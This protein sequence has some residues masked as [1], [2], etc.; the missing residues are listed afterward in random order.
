VV[1][2]ERGYLG[3]ASHATEVGDDVMIGKG[4]SVPLIMR[5]CGEKED[6]FRLVGDAYIHGIMNGEAFDERK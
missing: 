4:S 3:L 5:R 1:R 6:E 2:T